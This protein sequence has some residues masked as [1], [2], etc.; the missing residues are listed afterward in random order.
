MEKWVFWG[1]F[2]DFREESELGKFERWFRERAK[3]DHLYIVEMVGWN[4]HRD[5]VN[6]HYILQQFLHYSNDDIDNMM[7]YHVS[8]G[9][10]FSPNMI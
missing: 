4:V 1:F 6:G 8:Q 9:T 7:Y 2:D 5:V 3:W 10:E